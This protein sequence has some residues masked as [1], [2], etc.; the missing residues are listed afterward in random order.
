MDRRHMNSTREVRRTA[1]PWGALALFLLLSFAYGDSA[2]AELYQYIDLDGTIHLTNVP[3]DPRFKRIHMNRNRIGARISSERLERIIARNSRE[4]GLHPS[5]L[6]AVIK[7]ESDFVPMAVSKVGAMGLMQLMPET[8]HALEVQ[9]P[10]NPEQNVAGGAKYLRQLI[11][12]FGG[13]LL[14][15]LAAYNAGERVV[16]RYGGLPPFKETQRYVAKVFRYYRIYLAKAAAPPAKTV[17]PVASWKR[18]RPVFASPSP[19]R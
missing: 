16:E 13:D 2:S 18:S 3:T 19:S 10:F 6:R 14:L 7:A 17:K 12:R 4:H 15:A 9:D 8:A 11:D 1:F 5:L